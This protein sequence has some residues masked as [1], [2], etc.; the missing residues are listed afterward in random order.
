V[1]GTDG[2]RSVGRS[3]PPV[4]DRPTYAGVVDWQPAG[5]GRAVDPTEVAMDTIT[6]REALDLRGKTITTF[7]AYEAARALS[8]VGDGGVVENPHR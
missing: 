3:A 5:C 8:R 1:A 4:A 7:I 2:P 6:D